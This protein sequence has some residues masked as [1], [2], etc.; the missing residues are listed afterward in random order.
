M[1]MLLGTRRALFQ[2]GGPVW[3]PASPAGDGGVLPDHWYLVEPGYIWQDAGVTPAASAGDVIGRLEDRTANA[4][5]VNQANAGNKPTL[6]VA[7]GGYWV[8]RFDGIDD[9]LKGAF[10]T[11][12]AIAQPHTAFIV[13]QLD[14]AVIADGN[15]RTVVCD[16]TTSAFN[17]P[18]TNL[19]VWNIWNG[20]NLTGGAADAAWNIWTIL[21]NG[22]TSQFWHNGISEAGPGN[23]GALSAR[24]G[25]YRRAAGALLPLRGRRCGGSGRRAAPAA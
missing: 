19:N 8:A 15:Y 1:T 5:H 21:C 17:V 2:V 14:A 13:A 23:S 16:D 4:D 18:K 11:G 24:G 10:T 12:G 22:A 9:Y 25:V 6:Q 3:T 20:V 7:A